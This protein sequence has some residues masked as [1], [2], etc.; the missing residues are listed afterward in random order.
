ME[1]F[2]K[3]DSRERKVLMNCCFGH[4]MSHFNMLAFPALVIPLTI[5]F[6]MDMAHVLEISF[7]MYLMFGVSALPWG[8]A[9]DK[10]G[11]R[12]FFLLFYL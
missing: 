8:I 10:W 9:G 2:D 7:L 3:M 1:K 5:Q 4:F 11:S 6:D 12:P